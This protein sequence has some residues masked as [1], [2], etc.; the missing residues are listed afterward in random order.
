MAEVNRLNNDYLGIVVYSKAGRDM[1]RKFIILDIINDD[2]VYIC[3]GDLRTIE[4]PKKKR[5]K[6]LIITDI[7]AKDIKQELLSNKKV[8]NLQIKKFL[9]L[10]GTNRE[11]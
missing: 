4:K 2:Y 3:D 6:H 7:I 11:V 1:D 5:I 10:I 8:S 9:Q